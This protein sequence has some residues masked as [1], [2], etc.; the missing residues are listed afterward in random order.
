[1]FQLLSR[2]MKYFCKIK[3]E[4]IDNIKYLVLEKDIYGTKGYFIFMHDSLNNPSMF[5][6]WYQT[7]DEAYDSALD[8]FGI[9]KKDWQ[10]LEL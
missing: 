10:Q 1:M 6:S 9:K 8:E 3:E 5:D 4:N 7:I 2:K